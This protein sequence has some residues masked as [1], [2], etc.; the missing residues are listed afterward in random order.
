MLEVKDLVMRF[1]TYDGV[2]NALNGVSFKVDKGE[3]FGLVGE[4]GCGKSVTCYSILHLLP[5]TAKVEEGSVFLEDEDLLKAPE[6]RLREI[7][8]GEIAMIFQDP[9]SAILSIIEGLETI[10]LISCF[11]FPS[12]SRSLENSEISFQSSS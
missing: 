7:R 6:K 4:T 9:L 1:Y 2:V 5:S 8:G 3:I 10:V 12:M 11:P